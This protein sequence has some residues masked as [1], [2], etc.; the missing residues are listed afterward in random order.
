MLLT[1]LSVYNYLLNS[2]KDITL[3]PQHFLYFLPL[4]QG[5]GSFLPTFSLLT[6]VFIVGLSS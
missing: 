2:L 6:T 4:P 5:H 3:Q 1:S